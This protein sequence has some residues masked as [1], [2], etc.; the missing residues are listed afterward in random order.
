MKMS[1]DSIS[2]S[3]DDL[4]E[5]MPIEI[6]VVPASDALFAS[7]VCHAMTEMV[8]VTVSFVSPDPIEPAL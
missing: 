7:V 6:D 4:S 5:I 3:A 8:R 1:C 2:Y